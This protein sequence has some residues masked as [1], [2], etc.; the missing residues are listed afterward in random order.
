MD[1][2]AML[3]DLNQQQEQLKTD[4]VTMEREF[5]QKK[6]QFIRIQ[7]AIE[8]LNLVDAGGPPLDENLPP[9]PPEPDVP[10]HT[11]AAK[12]LNV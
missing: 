9:A 8:A 3:D 5:N 4:L 7:G 10:D 11:E 12:E 6:E 2:Q 1:K